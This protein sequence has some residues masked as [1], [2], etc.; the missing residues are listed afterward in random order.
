MIYNC[1]KGR[2]EK[3]SSLWIKF[4]MISYANRYKKLTKKETG[5][6]GNLYYIWLIS[7]NIVLVCVILLLLF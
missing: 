1:L 4:F 5:K 6:V 3:V 7:I 2:G